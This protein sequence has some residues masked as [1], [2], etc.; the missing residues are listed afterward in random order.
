MDPSLSSE[1][2][3]SPSLLSEAPVEEELAIVGSRLPTLLM[4]FR[5]PESTFDPCVVID[6]LRSLYLEKR[7]VA[8]RMTLPNISPRLDDDLGRRTATVDSSDTT[9]TLGDGST[10]EDG[11][12]LLSRRIIPF[13][14]A[15]LLP[16]SSTN[17]RVSD[18]R[19]HC[20]LTI[21]PLSLSDDRVTLV[22]DGGG[23]AIGGGGVKTPRGSFSVTGI[24]VF[25][26]GPTF[27]LLSPPPS[28]FGSS[29]LDRSS[30]ESTISRL[31]PSTW[32]DTRDSLLDQ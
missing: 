25:C 29:G 30:E 9:P 6:F 23:F 17:N 19:D 1:L 14:P 32:V 18:N 2:A 20:P 5:L 3:W 12:L 27:Q 4:L 10:S 22:S 15:D 26:R 24:R 7:R 11:L 31:L 8:V 13:R 21:G 16:S 28:A